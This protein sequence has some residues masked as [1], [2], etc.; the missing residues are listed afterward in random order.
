MAPAM[1]GAPAGKPLLQ[2]RLLALRC[3]LSS[4][5][6]YSCVWSFLEHWLISLFC[7]APPMD[8]PPFDAPPFDA[9]TSPC[10]LDCIDEALISMLIS[11]LQ[12]LLLQPDRLAR[13]VPLVLRGLRDPLGPLV[14]PAPPHSVRLLRPFLLPRRVVPLILLHVARCAVWCRW[15]P[16]SGQGRCQEASAR[17]SEGCAFSLLVHRFPNVLAVTRNLF[18]T[19]NNAGVK[20][21]QLHWKAVADTQLKG[22]VWAELKVVPISR[23]SLLTLSFDLLSILCGDWPFR[24]RTSCS[25]PASSSSNSAWLR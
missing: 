8:A 7:A 9:R 3:S 17:A 13:P 6:F 18:A 19:R 5:Y 22:T 12:C 14:P 20:M 11:L 15:L 24:T 1:D 25:I 4:L 21:K 2:S 10:C 16:R 23:L